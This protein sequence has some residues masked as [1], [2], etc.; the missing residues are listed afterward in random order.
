MPG[1]WATIGLQTFYIVLTMSM[2]FYLKSQNKKADENE[3]I[4]LEG[5][6]DFRYAP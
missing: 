5:V 2:S 1:M 3:H 6:K 4:H